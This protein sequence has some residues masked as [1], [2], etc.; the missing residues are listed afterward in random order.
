M[1]SS[2]HRRVTKSKAD[3]LVVFVDLIA[4]TGPWTLP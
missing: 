4:P 1:M 2:Q 3:K